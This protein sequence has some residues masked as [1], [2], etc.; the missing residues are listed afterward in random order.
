MQMCGKPEG[1]PLISALFG[2][3]I[4]P[5]SHNDPCSGLFGLCF[6]SIP[7]PQDAIVAAMQV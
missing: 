1:C 5:F 2:L 6:G 7:P 4:Y 3:V